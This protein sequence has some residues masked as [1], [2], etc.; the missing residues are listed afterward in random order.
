MTVFVEDPSHTAL[1][2]HVQLGYT[3]SPRTSLWA[4]AGQQAQIPDFYQLYTGVNTDL[5]ITNTSQV[6]SVDQ[7]FNQ[8][9]LADFG[10]RH[11]FS[12][13][14]ALEAS[15]YYKDHAT[16]SNLRLESLQ[17]PLNGRVQDIKMYRSDGGRSAQGFDIKAD[18]M[19]GQIFTGWVAYSYVHAESAIGLTPSATRPHSFT[20]ALSLA[21]PQD[22]QAGTT[23]GAIGRN[24][25]VYTIFRFANGEPYTR[26]PAESGNEFLLSGELCTRQIEGSPNSFRLPMVQ[27][28]DLRLSKGFEVR[29]TFVNVFVDVRN[30]LN[31]GSTHT[32][33]AVTGTTESSAELSEVM[34]AELN[35]YDREASANGARQSNGDILLP[36]S[37]SACGDWYSQGGRSASP[38]CVYLIR[39]EQRYGNGDGAFD[40]GEQEQAIE[41]F[42]NVLR[43]SS[44]FTD[45][46]RRIRLGL[47]WRF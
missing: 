40:L 16:E 9:N 15:V 37:I 12:R 41:A 22:W 30:L 2:P 3:I 14:L 21:L 18:I 42:Y 26:C 7:E 20:G 34:R 35:S 27:R 8:V 33:Y 4:S 13:E 38:S 24:V 11:R 32:V 19:A 45:P 31:L 25:G 10:L 17:D 36:A 39:A 5:S 43:G 47:E 44:N 46:P 6:F 23:I 28:L 1:T 29:S